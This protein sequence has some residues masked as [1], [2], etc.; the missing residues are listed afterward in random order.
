MFIL[1]DIFFMVEWPFNPSSHLATIDM[2]RKLG[3]CVPFFG[4]AASP[5]NTMLPGPRP[6][7]VPSGILIH[8]AIWPQYM[9][10]KLGGCCAPLSGEGELGPHVTRC[11]LGQ[12]LPQCQISSC[13][14]QIFGHNTPTLQTGQRD[15][16]YRQQS[17]S[18]GRT[19]LQIVTPKQML[20][21]VVLTLVL[22]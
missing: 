5:S 21:V 9:G 14:I 20:P 19:V 2:G 4:G 22:G 12:G 3:G 18:I 7:S 1:G 15:R 6:T 17:D 10:R 13:S 11:H 16:Q 8:P